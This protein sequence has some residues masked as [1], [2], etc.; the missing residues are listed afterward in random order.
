MEMAI[1][2][3]R[4]A[5]QEPRIQ[6]DATDVVCAFLAHRRFVELFTDAGGVQLLLALPRTQHTYSGLS[7]CL[8]GLSA[9]VRGPAGL[10]LFASKV[11]SCLEQFWRRCWNG[12][13][14]DVIARKGAD[15]RWYFFCT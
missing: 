11:L 14:W 7:L 8:Y 4:A 3:L 5:A 15:G 1:G 2:L 10:S 6:F 12:V 9:Q 13:V